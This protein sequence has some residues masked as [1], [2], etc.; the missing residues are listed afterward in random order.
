MSIATGRQCHLDAFL[1]RVFF[2][3]VRGQAWCGCWFR[4]L[5]RN[6]GDLASPMKSSNVIRAG[7]RGGLGISSYEWDIASNIPC[8][9]WIK[10][11]GK[12][13]WWINE[14]EAFL[15][16]KKDCNLSYWDSGVPGS[17]GKKKM[18]LFIRLPGCDKDIPCRWPQLC[19]RENV[20]SSYRWL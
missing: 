2:R 16:I 19:N 17:K 5:F 14:G 8:R 3:V 7:H 1:S 6:A 18:I 11:R 9:I 15:S 10:L 12:M 4:Y 20:L 13:C